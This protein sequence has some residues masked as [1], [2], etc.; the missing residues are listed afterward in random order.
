ML[1]IDHEINKV[2]EGLY[3]EAKHSIDIIIYSISLPK[4]G[5]SMVYIMCFRALE[6]AIKRGIKT[7][8]ILE[9]WKEENP[10]HDSQQKAHDHFSLLGAEVTYA[11]KGVLFHA[12][13]WQF[14][15]VKLL[16]GSHNSTEAGFTKSKNISILVNETAAN[17]RFKAY[18]NAEF[19]KFKALAY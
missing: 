12:K 7:R 19:T 3:H 13:T 9:K 6:M 5:S 18:F 10:Q 17:A 15:N 14:D 2:L 8:I 16:I 11:S 1:I 4:R